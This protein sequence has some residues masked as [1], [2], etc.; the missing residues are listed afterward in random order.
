MGL[1]E[2]S[3]LLLRII[4]YSE[5]RE[6]ERER[7]KNLCFRKRQTERNA[8]SFE[9]LSWEPFGGHNGPLES[10]WLQWFCLNHY[11]CLFQTGTAAV[12]PSNSCSPH[13]YA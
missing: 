3:S 12:V 11:N 10:E 8:I 13:A 1:L 4:H 9:E 7:E 6:R 5:R 2:R